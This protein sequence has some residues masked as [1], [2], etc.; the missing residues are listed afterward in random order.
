MKM[1]FKQM[2]NIGFYLSAVDKLG[3][4]K[5]ETF[6]T[7]DLFENKGFDAVL[8]NIH[9]L[10]REC[11]KI[12]GYA[13]PLLG[14]KMAT[15]TPRAFT[16]EQLSRAKAEQTLICKGSHG[17]ATAS[18]NTEGFRSISKVAVAGLEGLGT[19]G[20]ATLVGKGSHS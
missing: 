4:P 1:P 7:V 13:G 15:A 9:A 6:M 11:Q 8:K 12:S 10:A 3:V 2:E 20:E 19:G 17:G 14:P 18:G 16:D 5:F